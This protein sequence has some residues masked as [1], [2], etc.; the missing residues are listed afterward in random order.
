VPKEKYPGIIYHTV[1]IKVFHSSPEVG[2][3][4]VAWLEKLLETQAL[5]PPEVVVRNE[6]GLGG[7]NDALDTLRSGVV[8]GK[9]IVVDLNKPINSILPVTDRA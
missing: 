4:L 9:R 1:P 5:I 3:G 7:I 8:G 6:G 2:E